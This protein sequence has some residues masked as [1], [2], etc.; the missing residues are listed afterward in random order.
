MESRALLSAIELDLFSAVG[1]GSTAEAAAK[2]MKTD[3]RA[4]ASLMN[5]LAAIKALTKEG[6]VFHNAPLTARFLAQ[7]SPDDQRTAA[8]HLVNLWPRWSTLTECVKQGTSVAMLSGERRGEEATVAFIAA[9]H[10]NASFRAPQVAGVLDLAGVDSVLDLGGG[11]GAYAMAFARKKPGLAVTLF[12]LP[13]VVPL[14]Q[15]YIQEA[16]LEGKIKTIAGDM[17]KD[18]YGTDYGM[19][20]ISAICHMYSPDEN[21]ALFSRIRSALKDGGQFV[22]QDF[23]LNDAKTAPRMGALFALNMLVN[24]RGGSAYSGQEYV[25]W[26]IKA[27]FK[28]ARVVPLPGP[29]SLVTARK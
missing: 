12:D 9:M 17:Q 16:G 8:M 14:T 28:D 22:I 21:L 5:A 11:S 3:P 18:A 13:V 19:V 7:G 1:P 24:T 23:I 29:T 2:R 26:L 6:E 20:F 4:T 27:G 10:R 15:K 25:E